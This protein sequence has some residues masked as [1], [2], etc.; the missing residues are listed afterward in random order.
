[1][2]PIYQIYQYIYQGVVSSITHPL[3]PV[4][5]PGY[6]FLKYTNPN[7]DPNPNPPRHSA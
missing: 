4:E 1:M 7:P 5:P 6:H 3:E 2:E